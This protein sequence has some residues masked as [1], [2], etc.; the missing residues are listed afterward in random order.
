MPAETLNGRQQLFFQA[1]FF[2]ENVSNIPT[3]SGHAIPILQLLDIAVSEVQKLLAQLKAHK[4]SEPD[5]LSNRFLKELPMELALSLIAI[6]NQPISSGQLSEDWSNVNEAVNYS[7]VSLTSVCHK[8]L[9]H[10]LGNIW[11][12]RKLHLCKTQLLTKVTDL[13]SCHNPGLYNCLLHKL[14]HYGTQR[15]INSWISSFPKD[16]HQPI[17]INSEHLKKFT[18]TRGYPMRQ[19]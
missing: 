13:M 4:A 19:L 18:R 9:E 2:Q 10:M 8:L 3:L 17:M 16:R 6:F 1:M 14:S 15:N 7:L 11:T 12:L 5:S